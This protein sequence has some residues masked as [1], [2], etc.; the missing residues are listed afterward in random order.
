MVS[1][2][3]KFIHFKQIHLLTVSFW[4][5]R[6]ISYKHMVRACAPR[7]INNQ[8]CLKGK[9]FENDSLFLCLINR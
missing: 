2:V 9:D 4:I 7:R 1:D 8:S 6:T 5:V 3:N